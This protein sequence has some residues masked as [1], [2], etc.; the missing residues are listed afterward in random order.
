MAILA[1]ICVNFAI[2]LIPMFRLLKRSFCNLIIRYKRFKASKIFKK[3]LLRRT[4]EEKFYDTKLQLRAQQAEFH[5]QVI[6]D[7]GASS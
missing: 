5:N 6:N 1:I 7:M 3:Y 4:Q 2:N